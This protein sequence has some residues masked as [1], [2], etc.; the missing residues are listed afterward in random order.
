MPIYQ[1]DDNWLL[2]IKEKMF[3]D[4][5]KQNLTSRVRAQK[6]SPTH[7]HINIYIHTETILNYIYLWSQVHLHTR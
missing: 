7:M 3:I 1:R 5:F 6:Q 4:R 2:Q